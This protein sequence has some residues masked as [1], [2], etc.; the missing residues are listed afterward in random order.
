[1]RREN[2]LQSGPRGAQ[3]LGKPVKRFGVDVILG[4]LDPDEACPLVAKDGRQERKQAQRAGRCSDL[5]HPI[6]HAAFGLHEVNST[7]FLRHAEVQIVGHSNDRFHR[8]KDATERLTIGL[9]SFLQRLE[10]SCEV[11]SELIEDIP[12]VC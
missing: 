2:Q 6:L 12:V 5:V 9:V 1:M 10:P 3:D 4:L 11:T 8:R 7:G